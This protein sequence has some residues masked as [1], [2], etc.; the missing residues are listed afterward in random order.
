MVF[1]LG[2]SFVHLSIATDDADAMRR[3]FQELREKITDTVKL[4]SGLKKIPYGIHAE[5]DRPLAT[6]YSKARAQHRKYSV[7]LTIFLGTI[8]IELVPAPGLCHFVRMLVAGYTTSV[9]R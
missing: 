7:R 2:V 9:N 6:M 4:C 1:C 5:S 8:H 3:M